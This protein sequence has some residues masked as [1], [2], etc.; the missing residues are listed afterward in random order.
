[1]RLAGRQHA[2]VDNLVRLLQVGVLIG[3]IQ[4]GAGQGHETG[5]GGLED[6]K[7]GDELE[8]RVYP[9]RLGGPGRIN[10]I[11]MSQNAWREA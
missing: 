5:T 11:S 6:A 2:G 10:P 3:S 1:M 8:E 9:G 7:G 4:R